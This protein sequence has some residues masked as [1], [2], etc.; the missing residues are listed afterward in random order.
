VRR[1]LK[2]HLAAITG[3]GDEVDHLKA[4]ADR[5]IAWDYVIINEAGEREEVPP[6]ASDPENG[7]QQFYELPNDVLVWLKDEIESAHLPKALTSRSSKPAGTTDSP[8]PAEI[9]LDPERPDS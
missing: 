5:V 8:T 4:L 7:W 1:A 9:E 3:T 2:A 6:P